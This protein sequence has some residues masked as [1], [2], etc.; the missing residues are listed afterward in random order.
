MPS[1]EVN[2]P[3]NPTEIRAASSAVSGV[4]AASPA[5]IQAG[6]TTSATITVPISQLRNVARAGRRCQSG[7]L[8]SRAAS[9]KRRSSA[10]HS[11]Q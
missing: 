3:R 5:T 11:S 1:S 7:R 6:I 8:F 4:F 2:P 9:A 10:A